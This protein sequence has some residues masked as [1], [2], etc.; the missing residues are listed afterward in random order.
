[1]YDEK[2]DYP[3]TNV[4][5]FGSEEELNSA[6]P[7]WI[8][9]GR[10][11]GVWEQSPLANQF[12]LGR[13]AT[14]EDRQEVIKKYRQWLWNKIQAGDPTVISVLGEINRKTVLVCWCAPEPCHAEVVH[15][16]AA[17]LREQS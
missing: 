2:K 13:G 7:K 10:K 1:M 3:V 12:K 16:A 14:D 9:V 17:W 15:R 8:Y 4:R 5:H 11:V 6:F